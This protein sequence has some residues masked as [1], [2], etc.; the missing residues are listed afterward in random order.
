MPKGGQRDLSKEQRWRQ[1]FAD[2]QRTGLSGAEYCRQHNLQYTQWNDWQKR[3][4]RLDADNASKA[5]RERMAARAHKIAD[6]LKESPLPPTAIEFAEVQVREERKAHNC[7]SQAHDA[8]SLEIVF[9]N[10]TKLRLSA[11][12]P[13]NLLASVVDMLEDR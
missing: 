5:R 8:A 2:W 4:R 6:G 1:T 13:L 10:G 12:C 11:S 7:V 9:P 3:V